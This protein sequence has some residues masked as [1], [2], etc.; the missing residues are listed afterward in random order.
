MQLSQ[1]SFIYAHILLKPKSGRMEKNMTYVCS[2][3][4]GDYTKFNKLLEK[5]G[6]CDDDIMYVVGDI[7][8]FHEKSMELLCDLS[9]RSNIYPVLGKHEKTALAMLRGFDEMLRNGKTPDNEYVDVMKQWMSD[10]GQTTFDGFRALSKEMKEGIIEYLSEFA[11][12]EQAFTDDGDYIIVYSGI[13]DFA[14]DRELDDYDAD[15]FI[16]NT[17][18]D[19]EYF[20]DRFVII[21]CVGGGDKINRVGNRI[22]MDCT[23]DNKI[24]CLC[25][26]NN[27]E[28]YV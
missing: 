3:I 6:F 12:Y 20:D 14:P 23:K 1:N 21:G 5:I 18:F 7:I 9:M 2:N 19:T 15:S 10:G 4:R 25:L 13:K 8:D 27:K 24:T 22:M 16:Y 26:E 28:F 11:T 17:S